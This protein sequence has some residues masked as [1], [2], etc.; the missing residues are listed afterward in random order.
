MH[1]NS[2]NK[3]ILMVTDAT[4]NVKLVIAVTYFVSF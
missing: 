3:R 1:H 4:F 2:D